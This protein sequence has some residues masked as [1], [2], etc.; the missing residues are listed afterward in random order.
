M[1]NVR[2]TKRYEDM[3]AA[4]MWDRIGNPASLASWHPGVETTELIDGGRTRINTVAGGAQVVEPIVEQAEHHYTFR[5]AESPLPLADFQSTLRVRDDDGHA[6]V[7]EWDAAFKA[8]D[9]SEAEATA[10]VRGFFQAGLDALVASA[11]SGRS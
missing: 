9:V 8:K 7:V 10:L 5:I 11:P 6:C 3:T 2:V 1:T 4:T